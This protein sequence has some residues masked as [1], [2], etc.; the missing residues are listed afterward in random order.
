MKRSEVLDCIKEVFC[1]VT[2][3]NLAEKRSNKL[4]KKLEDLGMLPPG[5]PVFNADGSY[6]ESINIWENED[7]KT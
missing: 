3:D 7:E 5:I 4:L 1:E 6:R 2:Y